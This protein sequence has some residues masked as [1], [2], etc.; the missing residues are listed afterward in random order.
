MK[1]P[2]VLFISQEMDPYS[3]TGA[4]SKFSMLAPKYLQEAGSEIRILTPKFGSINERR[5]RLHE[6]VRLSGI[7]ISINDNDNPLLIKVATLP[8]ARMQVYFL[9]NEE[10]FH[11][12]CNLVDKHGV[13]CE[14]NDERMMFFCRG[15]L[16]TV[17]KLG[18]APDIIILNGW[19]TA[20]F[21][22]L[23]K[24]FYADK[25]VFRDSKI[26]YGFS[27]TDFSETMSPDFAK[28]LVFDGFEASEVEEYKAANWDVLTRS[29]LSNSDHVLVLEKEH[30]VKGLEINKEFKLPVF[31]L[32]DNEDWKEAFLEFTQKISA[33]EEVAL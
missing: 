26:V 27:D 19:F 7:N 28:K 12:K 29:A 6:V 30:S 2:K 1:T 11:R 18:W 8:T 14:D 20:L 23:F 13:F 21:P 33:D 24:K 9:D 32:S 31:D 16:E 25:P 22:L 10:Y 3:P 5:H 4:A 17:V 15:A